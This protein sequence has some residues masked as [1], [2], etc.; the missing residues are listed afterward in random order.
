MLHPSQPTLSLAQPTLSLAQPTL[1]ASRS[2]WRW[3]EA[4]PRLAL[5]SA[6]AMLFAATPAALAGE[7]V[8]AAAS[9]APPAALSILPYPAQ[10]LARMA[11]NLDKNAGFVVATVA[12]QPITKGDL[13]D[14][15]RATPVSLASL[16]YKALFTRAMDQLLRLR[17][18]VASARKAGV[19][20]DP[21]VRRR[22]QSAADRVLAEAWIDRQAAAAVAEPALRARYD[23]DVAGKPGPEE[24]RAQVILVPSA[25]EASDLIARIRQGADFGDLA[26]QYSQ[27]LSAAQGGDIGYVRLDALSAEVGA[28]LFALAPGQ[29]TDYPVRALPGYFVLRVEGR[30]QRAT[31]AFDDVRPELAS[32]LRREA[33][34]AALSALT[35]DIKLQNAGDAALEPAGNV[36]KPTKQ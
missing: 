2:Q 5:A 31:P 19:D 16:G 35:S 36:A 30:R 34:A 3:R 7:T 22:E 4:K 32:A 18:A 24:V 21:A 15:I 25:G 29:V 26:R 20:S 8:R 28:V 6:L 14:A 23:R 11:D 27:D 33:A 10:A 9:A 17:L 12:G 13:A 1:G